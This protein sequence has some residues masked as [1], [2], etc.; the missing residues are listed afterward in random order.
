APQAQ[1][2]MDPHSFSAG[3]FL[4]LFAFSACQKAVPSSGHILITDYGAVGDSAT[5]NTKAIQTAIDQAEKKGGGTVTIPPG[6][7]MSGTIFL[8]SN[9][10][11]EV[12]G[13]ATLLGSPNIEDYTKLSWGHNKDRQPWH[14]IVAKEQNNVR[15]IGNGMIDGNGPAFWTEDAEKDEKGNYVAPRWILAKD[16][17]VSPLIQFEH[18]ENVRLEDFSVKTG[19]GWNIHLFNS[20]NIKISGLDIVNNL[21]SPNSDGIDINGS[22]DVIISDCYIRTCDDAICLK[23]SPLAM[24]T[25][26][27]TVTNCIMETLC[28]GL[29][30]GASESFHDMSDIT[31]SNCVIFGSSRAIGMYSFNGST[32]RNINISNIVANTNSPMVLNRPIH[33]QI[34]RWEDTT[35]IGKIEDVTISGFTCETDGRIL[36]SAADGTAI[37]NLTLRDVTLKYAWIE[38]PAPIAA[39]AKSRQFPNKDKHP[40]LLAAPAAIAAENINNLRIE[41]LQVIWPSTEEVPLAWQHPERIENGSLAVRKPVYDKVKQ[42]EMNVLWGKNLNGG[43]LRSFDLKASSNDLKKYLLKE[44]NIS[45][46]DF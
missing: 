16:K 35:Q 43:Y 10:T 25:K 4:S 26:R 3:F 5:L 9:V 20:K 18:C 28:V 17:K 1:A 27:V 22:Q 37:E 23:A 44:S 29:K 21:Y 8:K 19:G 12:Q 38:D 36:L 46:N 6:V 2:P 45:V 7:F 33:M 11:L 34:E 30:M 40:E 31:I 42:T 41:N 39:K 15:I 24:E 14:L 13:G 32:Y